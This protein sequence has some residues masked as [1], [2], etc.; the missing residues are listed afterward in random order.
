LKIAGYQV[1][2]LADN[3]A[4]P[5][6]EY[7][8]TE[9]VGALQGGI[10]SGLTYIATLSAAGAVIASGGSVAALLAATAVAGSTSGAIGVILAKIIGKIHADRLE[11]QLAH[12]GL[13]VWVKITDDNAENLVRLILKKYKAS[14][15]HMHTFDSALVTKEE[16]A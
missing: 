10:I 11:D 3:P 8:P 4:T 5:R 9:N 2:D 12:G 7:I 15:I 6:T 1:Q 13:L 16:F 14:D